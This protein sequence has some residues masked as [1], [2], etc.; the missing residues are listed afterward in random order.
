VVLPGVLA[1]CTTDRSGQVTV[2]GAVPASEVPV[3]AARVVDVSGARVVLAQPAAG[4]FVAFSASCT[5]AG[6]PVVA[7]DGMLLVCPNHGSEFDASDGS[8]QRGPAK[9]PLATVPV[10]RDGDDLVLG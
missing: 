10:Q 6:T 7:K 4:E 3:G 1:A 2:S 8:V 5:H 9:Q